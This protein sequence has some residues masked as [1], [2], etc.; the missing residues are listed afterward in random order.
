MKKSILL[1]CALILAFASLAQPRQRIG[2][3]E[4]WQFKKL[5][6]ADNVKFATA[7][8]TVWHPVDV[9]H[10]WNN[11]DMQ[12]AKNSYYAGDAVYEKNYVPEEA[13]KSRRHYIRFEGV[14]EQAELFVN[15]VWVG[16]HKGGYSAFCFDITDFLKFGQDNKIRVKVSNKAAADVIPVN[17][18]LFGVYGGIYRPVEIIVTAPTHF[19]T[20]DYASSGIYIT[21][22]EVSEQSA[23]VHVKAKIDTKRERRGQYEYE[24]SIADQQGNPVV[25]DKQEITVEPAGTQSFTASFKIDNPHLWNGL[26]DPYLYKVTA[27]LYE[28]GQKIDEVIQPLGL[29]TVVAVAGD[30][31]Y[32]NG[33]K[34]PMY[35]VCRHQDR[36]GLGSAL[37][38]KEHAEDLELIREIG[39]TTIR[40][41]HYQQSDYIYSKC[42]SIGFLIWAE[43]PFVNRVTTFEADNAKQQLTELIRQSFNHP[44]IYVWGLHNEVYKPHDYTAALTAQLH[45]LAKTEDPDR[46]TV[47]VNGY[48]H[49]NHPVN[50]N[51]DI[52]GMNRYFGWYERTIGAM[53]E[54]IEKLEKEYPDNKLILSEYGAEANINQQQEKLGESWN[55]VSQFYPE[56]YATKTHETHW[57]IIAKHP[58]IIASYLWN[59][60]DFATPATHQGGVPARNMKGMV[61]F[62][63]KVKKDVFYWYK[64]NWSKEP[65]LYLTQRRL[66]E[67]ENKVT[68]ITVYS[69]VGKP[70]V[71]L[72]GRKL[73]APE[74]GNTDVHYILKDVTLKKGKNIIRTEVTKDGQ[75]YSDQIEWHYSGKTVN[76]N[77]QPEFKGNDKE[78]GGL[79]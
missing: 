1:S 49:M 5:P 25:S 33:K 62:D 35:G 4:G 30:G 75:K 34:V 53:N 72:N 63:R 44:S 76:S 67:R 52:Q 38:N 13:Q 69:N 19:A 58:Y 40:F 64:A 59:M 39:A 27:S 54:W 14:G 28:N 9:P 42:D 79:F 41:A 10:T 36:E 20:T 45:D 66:T 37:T 61:T 32:L 57:P 22:K 77:A 74:Q 16:R 47:S 71:F 43:I 48:G 51:A 31:F 11:I 3:N 15:D 17:H 50:R 29:R 65:V 6:N 26:A 68:D 8:D 55:F 70:V 24:V 18:H 78:H 7:A 12:N 73:P 2:F 21:Q 46:Y 60:F 23:T 56:T